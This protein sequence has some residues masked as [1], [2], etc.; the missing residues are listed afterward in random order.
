MLGRM[1]L[2]WGLRIGWEFQ[3]H[4]EGQVMQQKRCEKKTKSNLWLDNYLVVWCGRLVIY[5]GQL[6]R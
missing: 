1:S 6:K 2:L 5:T 4:E 3:M